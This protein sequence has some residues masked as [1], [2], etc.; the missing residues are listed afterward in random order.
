MKGSSAWVTALLAV[1]L[2]FEPLHTAYLSMADPLQRDDL[3]PVMEQV[4]E[5]YQSGDTIYVYYNARPAFLYYSY[6]F[7]F[8]PADVRFGTR[9][10]ER[11]EAYL[12]EIDALLGLRRVWFVFSHDFSGSP[13]GG[14]RRYIL[15]YLRCEGTP[16]DNVERTGAAV[17]L[18]DLSAARAP[19]GCRP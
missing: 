11:P 17:D 4:V 13:T 5:R 2:L 9:T 7:R 6:L 18:F 15:R 12:D 8:T 19:A 14:E 3:R 1:I 16:M 10:R